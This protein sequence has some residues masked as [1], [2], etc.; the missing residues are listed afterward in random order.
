MLSKS[1]T[2]KLIVPTW[3]TYAGDS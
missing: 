1:D 2:Q 3:L